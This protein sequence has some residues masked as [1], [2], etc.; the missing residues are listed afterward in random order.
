MKLF[1][2]KE[3]NLWHASEHA[4]SMGVNRLIDIAKKADVWENGVKIL[5]I[6]PPHIRESVY[7]V[8]NGPWA[9]DAVDK[10]RHRA[11]Y[12]ISIAEMNNCYFMDASEFAQFGDSDGIHLTAASHK[13][14]ADAIAKKVK[15]I[16]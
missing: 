11:S 14:L 15:N 2:H 6:A 5:V 13:A 16:V 10:S 4:I 7:S 3:T 8:Y 1:P 12:L 9:D